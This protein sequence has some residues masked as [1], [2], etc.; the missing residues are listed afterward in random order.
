MVCG[1]PFRETNTS[2][3]QCRHF[4]SG[5]MDAELREAGGT[6]DRSCTASS[7]AAQWVTSHKTGTRSE[8][9]LEVRYHTLPI[10]SHRLKVSVRP[11][12]VPCLQICAVSCEFGEL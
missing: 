12:S 4:D 6:Q 10:G 9:Q 8:T 5:L 7:H 1:R 3:I 2:V 11:K